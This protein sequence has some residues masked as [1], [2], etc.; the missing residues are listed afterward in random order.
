VKILYVCVGSSCHVRGA[1]DVVKVFQKKIEEHGLKGSVSLKGSF[2]TGNCNEKGV[3][4]LLD[5]EVFV[6]I[7]PETAGEFFD[8]ELLPRLRGDGR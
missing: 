4:V 1:E 6:G 8:R 2:C 7:T 5:E 3:T